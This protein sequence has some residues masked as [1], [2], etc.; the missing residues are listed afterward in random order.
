M[1]KTPTVICLW[2][3]GALFLLPAACGG[4][5]DQDDTVV[6]T[7]PEPECQEDNDC[8]AYEICEVEACITGDR[9]DTL[10]AASPIY[11]LSG[12]E[13]PSVKKA[14]IQ[15]PGDIDHWA[16]TSPGEEWLRV[17]TR[18][19]EE[20]PSGLDTV[21]TV[22]APNGAVH[23]VMDEFPTGDIR[24][25]DSLMHVY[26]PTAGTW[27]FRVEDRSTYYDGDTPRG[28]VAF[29]YD[30][31]VE[32]WRSATVEPDSAED[33]SIEFPMVNGSTVYSWGIHF[34]FDGDVDYTLADMPYGDAPFEIWAPGSIPGS[35]AEPRVEVTDQEGIL[36]LRK[37]RV[38]E[39]GNAAYFDGPD[40]QWRVAVSDTSGQSGPESWTVLYLRTRAEGFGNPREVEPNDALGDST[41]LE[42]ERVSE[43]GTTT[44]RAFLQGRL[45]EG[46]LSDWYTV[47]VVDGGRLRT[48]CSSSSFGALGDVDVDLVGPMGELVDT[49]TD[50]TDFAPDIDREN[51]P[52]GVYGLRFFEN[53]GL[54]GPA[55]YYRCGVYVDHP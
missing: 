6:D 12:P 31:G 13:D 45:L 41:F 46:D 30:I 47:S 8:G 32:A 44:D 1:K 24:G 17:W 9:D 14:L 51:L 36:Y 53:A 18:T 27:V 54:S 11:Q 34:E 10:D 42:T 40:T 19:D 22:L 49:Y 50:G 25:F 55:I 21:L 39:T 52:E 43:G 4:D 35:P 15:E 3:L 16:Y 20:D 5:N 37:E 48:S 33:P 2:P 28:S 38:G 23:H 26:L 29:E 7:S